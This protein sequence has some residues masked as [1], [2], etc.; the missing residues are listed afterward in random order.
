MKSQN[1]SLTKELFANS[2]EARLL[3]SGY[4]LFDLNKN[5]I[6]LKADI[7]KD[8]FSIYELLKQKNIEHKSFNNAIL[9]FYRW[10]H[11]ILTLK[12]YK[13]DCQNKYEFFHFFLLLHRDLILFLSLL[14]EYFKNEI[15]KDKFK[16]FKKH[17]YQIYNIYDIYK[18]AVTK[19]K[20][21]I[22]CQ[23]MANLL[24]EYFILL[25]FIDDEVFFEALFLSKNILSD[26]F[27]DRY[28]FLKNKIL[29]KT[30]KIGEFD[31]NCIIKEYIIKTKFETIPY[32]IILANFDICNH[33][34]I[35]SNVTA[36][37]VYELNN[38]R[39]L[40]FDIFYYVDKFVCW[41][42]ISN[43]NIQNH[44]NYIQN[45]ENKYKM[46][47]FEFIKAYC[48]ASFAKTKKAVNTQMTSLLENFPNINLIDF[49]YILQNKLSHN[50]FTCFYDTNKIFLKTMKNLKN[51]KVDDLTV[52][53][54]SFF[55]DL[56]TKFMKD[57]F[58]S[59][60]K[61]I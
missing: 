45:C 25:S 30:S 35:Y 38:T 10:C 43:L 13:I 36:I 54:Y 26:D 56:I 16:N 22:N 4:N 6:A 58:T 5:E 18:T 28:G 29:N 24:N 19:I 20:Q 34:F 60:Q 49:I 48:N 12:H 11:N 8:L 55:F 61:Q 53:D 40:F 27:N 59:K 1:N 41:L 14:D 7:E 39:E 50:I 51:T 52:G 3:F 47:Y 9:C 17:Y 37:N 57:F 31:K 33:K 21:F 23:D 42:Q 2:Y 32:K 44:L 15:L 46:P